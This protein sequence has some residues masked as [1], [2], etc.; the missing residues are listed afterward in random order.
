M[1]S[2]QKRVPKEYEIEKV[3]RKP[4]QTDYLRRNRVG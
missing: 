3:K 1:E 2:S 4:S